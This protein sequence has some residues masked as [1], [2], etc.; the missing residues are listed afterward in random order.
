M[1][2]QSRE[3][4]TILFICGVLA[5]NYPVLD[6]FN[7]SWAPLGI[8]LLYFY[9]YL[10]WFVLIVVLIMVVERSEIRELTESHKSGATRTKGFSRPGGDPDTHEPPESP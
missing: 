9:L 5:I 8:P 10:A 4:I 6:L 7:R 2:Q 3:Y 1:R